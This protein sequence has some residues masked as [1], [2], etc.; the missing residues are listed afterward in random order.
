ML[1]H[2][3]IR[4]AG[5]TFGGDLLPCTATELCQLYSAAEVSR[6][7]IGLTVTRQDPVRGAITHTDL[8]AFHDRHATPATKGSVFL[9]HLLR[10]RAEQPAAQLGAAA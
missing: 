3:L 2:I 8:L 9:R 10:R 1:R 5:A 4:P 7:A 6:L